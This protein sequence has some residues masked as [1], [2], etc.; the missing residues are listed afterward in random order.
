MIYL[1]HWL[2]RRDG[3]RGSVPCAACRKRV[4]WPDVPPVTQSR[5]V[6]DGKE[7]QE[8]DLVAL[9]RVEGRF[10]LQARSSEEFWKEPAPSKV[11]SN[12]KPIWEQGGIG[13]KINV[14]LLRGGAEK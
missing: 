1:P 10:G 13:S 4:F 2:G 9:L 11:C 5:V 7:S 3:R 8:Q 12:R 14:F 6:A